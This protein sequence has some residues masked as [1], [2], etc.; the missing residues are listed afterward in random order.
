MSLTSV[1]RLPS[2]SYDDTALGMSKGE[3]SRKPSVFSAYFKKF[4]RQELSACMSPTP[5]LCYSAVFF[6]MLTVA[7]I[8]LGAALF[9]QTLE[10]TEVI[11]RYDN[12]TLNDKTRLTN[13]E[14]KEII[15]R[16]NETHTEN[17]IFSISENMNSPV[18]IVHTNTQI[19]QNTWQY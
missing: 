14:R 3:A 7:A 2:N 4:V 9:W 19:S 18:T 5:S 12:F 13:D 11:L 6:C 15:Q 10:N 1:S 8:P 16:G 17:H